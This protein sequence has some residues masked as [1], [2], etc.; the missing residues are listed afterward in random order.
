MIIMFVR[1]AEAKNDKITDFGKKQLLM[2]KK[3]NESFEFAKIYS[4][5]LNRCVATAKAFQ[6]KFSVDLE[7]LDGLKDRELLEHRKPQNED[8]EEWYENYLNPMFSHD[9]PEGCKEFLARN[10]T[11]FKRVINKHIDND[12]NIV[13]VAHSGTFYAL[14]A[15]VNGVYKNKF[16]NWYRIGTCSK[17][18]FE[19]NERI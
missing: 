1:H 15:Y 8:E 6:E 2:A 3:E 9:K 17:V 14:L 7:V 12:E 16:I 10:F 18:Y 19:I 4:S 13:L 5:P 11:Q